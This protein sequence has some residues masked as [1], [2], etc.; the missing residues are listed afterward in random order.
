MR[1]DIPTDRTLAPDFKQAIQATYSGGEQGE[2][3]NAES[4]PPLTRPLKIA[5]QEATSLQTAMKEGLNHA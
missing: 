4:P 1:L 3:S 2:S 5:S